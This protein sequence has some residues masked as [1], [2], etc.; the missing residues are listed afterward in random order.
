MDADLQHDETIL[1]TMLH[2]IQNSQTDIVVGSR[3]CASGSIGGWDSRRAAMSRFATMLSRTVV[4]QQLT[5][6]LSGFFMI[7]RETFH[8]IVRRLSGEGYK[9]LL[10]LFASSPEPLSFIEVPY[11]FRERTAGA[12]KLDA[13]VVWEYVLLIV[14][15]QFGHIIPARFIL[16]SFV[17]LSGVVVH[18]LALA[19]AFKVFGVDFPIAQTIATLIAMT[20]NFALNNIFTYQDRRLRGMRWLTGLFTFYLVCSIGVIAN[21]GVANV[22]FEH[23]YTWWL[24]GGAGALTGTVWNYAASSVLTWGQK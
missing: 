6:P 22:V 13:A 9:I 5:D 4:T 8:R 10:D 14:D 19:T 23:H 21:V 11:T 18:F 1:P 17:G 2:R 24:A 16:F 3:Y 12:S 15:K 7:R 20:T